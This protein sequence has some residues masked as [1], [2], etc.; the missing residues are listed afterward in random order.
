MCIC[1]LSL[2][3]FL[4]FLLLSHWLTANSLTRARKP[5]LWM[6]VRACVCLFLPMF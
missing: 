2:L 6:C 3:L 4:F 5:V 1:L